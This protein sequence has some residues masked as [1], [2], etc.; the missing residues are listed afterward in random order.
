M[1]TKRHLLRLETRLGELE[2]QVENF[3]S[4][5]ALITDVQEELRYVQQEHTAAFRRVL[6]NFRITC[7]TCKQYSQ[8]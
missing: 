1:R 4:D 5:L 6:H 8:G 2:A 7:K 3:R